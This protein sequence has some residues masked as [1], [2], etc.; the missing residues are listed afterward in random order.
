[1]G[2]HTNARVRHF[3][4]IFELNADVITSARCCPAA[5]MHTKVNIGQKWIASQRRSEKGTQ[6]QTQ[7]PIESGSSIQ[8]TAHV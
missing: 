2:L 7:P 5:M 8:H 6:T 4:I 3:S 1:M